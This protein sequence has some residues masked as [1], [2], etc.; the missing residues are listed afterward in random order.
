MSLSKW[1]FD[2]FACGRRNRRITRALLKEHLAAAVRLFDTNLD[3]WRKTFA[4]TPTTL[5][6]RRHPNYL[7][8]VWLGRIGI[9]AFCM[10]KF[11]FFKID[12]VM[13]Y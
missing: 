9:N 2:Q 5:Q 7:G 3:A 11:N 12:L 1:L 4:S 10:T 13:R 6:S 8:T